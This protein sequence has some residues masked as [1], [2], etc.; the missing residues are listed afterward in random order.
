[1]SM[2]TEWHSVAE[3]SG[4]RGQ[5]MKAS[6]LN[7]IPQVGRTIEEIKELV[8][9]LVRVYNTSFGKTTREEL[10]GVLEKYDYRALVADRDKIHSVELVTSQV[11]CSQTEYRSG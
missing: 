11:G 7:E 3:V 2:P 6:A 1:M 8:S 9:E 5:I 10:T 4:V